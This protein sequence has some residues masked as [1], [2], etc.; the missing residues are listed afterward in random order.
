MADEFNMSG[1]FQGALINIKSTLSNVQQ[2]VG[3]M[4]TGDAGARTELTNLIQ[5][6][7]DELQKLPAEQ[8]EYAQ[9]LAETTQALVDA[10][11]QQKPNPTMVQITSDGLLKAAKNLATVAPVVLPLA[12]QIVEVVSKIIAH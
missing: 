12:S 9:A 6:L 7:S 8:Q 2:S 3:A 5:Q 1:N 4:P 11:K 10:A